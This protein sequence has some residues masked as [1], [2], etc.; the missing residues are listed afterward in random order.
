MKVLIFFY[1][2]GSTFTVKGNPPSSV[3]GLGMEED[4]GA[5][6][7]NVEK[8]FENPPNTTVFHS[9]D[10][11]QWRWRQKVGVLTVIDTLSLTKPRV[12]LINVK[13]V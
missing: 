10:F 9:N 13:A 2:N 3:N 1:K 7:P 6:D 8:V 12:D 11:T 4:S 5:T